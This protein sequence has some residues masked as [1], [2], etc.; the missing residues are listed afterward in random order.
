LHAALGN[1][2][3]SFKRTGGYGNIAV[4]EKLVP[5]DHPDAHSDDKMW[6][7]IAVFLMGVTLGNLAFHLRTGTT[8][9]GSSA[10]PLWFSLPLAIF[11]GL[12]ALRAHG[13]VRVGVALFALSLLVGTLAPMIGIRGWAAWTIQRTLVFMSSVFLIV[14]LHRSTRVRLVNIA[15]LLL[16][17]IA[18]SYATQQF[19]YNLWLRATKQNSVISP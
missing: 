9:T 5:N 4:A 13:P 6:L 1:V 7:W 17:V 3:K 10:M 11:V 2:T 19:G 14:G 16:L 15:A 12:T 18:A 8:P